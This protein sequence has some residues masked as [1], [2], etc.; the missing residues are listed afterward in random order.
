MINGI[1]GGNPAVTVSYFVTDHLGS[2]AVITDESHA[3]SE[4]DAFDAWG[5]RRNQSDWSDD[6]TCALTSS[7]TRGFTGHEELDT[8]CL[9]NANARIYD[10]TLGRFHE[11]TTFLPG[12]WEVLKRKTE[13]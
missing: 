10:A 9:I 11:R 12:T 2:I 1:A 3:V 7:T 13:K 4:R 6:T 5:K 8:L